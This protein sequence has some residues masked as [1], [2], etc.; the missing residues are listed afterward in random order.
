[1]G[2]QQLVT[3]NAIHTQNAFKSVG[4]WR[5][6][7]SYLEYKKILSVQSSPKIMSLSPTYVSGYK[8]FFMGPEPL[9]IN[10]LGS[11]KALG[12]NCT[13]TW[14]HITECWRA[15]SMELSTGEQCEC[16]DVQ[17]CAVHM[18]CSVNIIQVT[19]ILLVLVVR[20]SWFCDCS[21]VVSLVLVC[22]I[23]TKLK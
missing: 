18:V 14:R 7:S 19:I 22:T 16:T 8:A 10:A 13:A 20:R 12:N 23:A 15:P 17:Q 11:F 2:R 6:V 1:M 4:S 3:P 21:E 9:K 5:P